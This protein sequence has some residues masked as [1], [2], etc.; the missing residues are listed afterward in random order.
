VKRLRRRAHATGD[1]QAGPAAPERSPPDPQ[2]PRDQEETA[3][4][5]ILRKLLGSARGARAAALVDSEGETVD[6]EGDRDPF[7]MRVAA[8]HFRIVLDEVAN[9]PN[10]ARAQWIAVRAQRRSFFVHALPERY[11]LVLELARIAGFHPPSAAVKACVRALTVEAGWETASAGGDGGATAWYRVA[12]LCDASGRPNSVRAGRR[13][14]AVEILGALVAPKSGRGVSERAWRVRLET[15]IEGTLAR[16]SGD[17]WYADEPFDT[18]P[19]T[20][21]RNAPMAPPSKSR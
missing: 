10:L 3:F 11:A 21:R 15:G 8:A 16:R 20:G 7:A 14:Y 18:P 17:L 2:E 9:Q 1:A 5:G 19:R 13:T 6:C 12:V 4:T